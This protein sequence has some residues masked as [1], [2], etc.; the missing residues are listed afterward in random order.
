MNTSGGRV[1][2]AL[3]TLDA[4]RTDPSLTELLDDDF[5]RFVSE[6]ETRRDEL[7]GI[8]HGESDPGD[9]DVPTRAWLEGA[10]GIE[11]TFEG[12]K[13]GVAEGQTPQEALGS[14]RMGAWLRE[15]GMDERE[16]AE[17]LRD[18]M[19]RGEPLPWERQGG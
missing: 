15:S 18:V 8:V 4:I 7:A 3:A 1:L 5:K 13:L 12:I 14:V 11:S 9:F 19:E 6:G 2:E 17:H 10:W 16:A